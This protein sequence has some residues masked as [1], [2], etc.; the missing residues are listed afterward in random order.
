MSDLTD[1]NQGVLMKYSDETIESLTLAISE[2]AEEAVSDDEDYFFY[3]DTKIEKGNGLSHI[4]ESSVILLSNLK[5]NS[6]EKYTK[7]HKTIPAYDMG[8]E[9]LI[10]HTHALESTM[11]V[12]GYTFNKKF[13]KAK[14]NSQLV[15]V[16]QK[17]KLFSLIDCILMRK[18][19]FNEIPTSKAFQEA[20]TISHPPP[21]LSAEN[22]TLMQY[23]E[24][25]LLAEFEYYSRAI[26][27]IPESTG[28]FLDAIFELGKGDDG[29]GGTYTVIQLANMFVERNYNI[30]QDVNKLPRKLLGNLMII[31]TKPNLR[32]YRKKYDSI[33]KDYFIEDELVLE[34]YIN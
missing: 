28:K 12:L 17:N 21:W 33:V 25:A 4:H 9:E 19:F 7:K 27:N 6:T 13:R 2:A 14:Q 11:D 34:I 10:N 29:Q 32:Y 26:L 15:N 20:A 16:L 18:E 1:P 24:S 22:D 31:A 30:F 23:E 5:D 3:F 8:L